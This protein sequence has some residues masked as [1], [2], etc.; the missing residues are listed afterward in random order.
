MASQ[1]FDD[2]D[3][4]DQR[5]KVLKAFLDPTQAEAMTYE[6]WGATKFVRGQSRFAGENDYN[7]AAEPSNTEWTFIMGNRDKSEEVF[8]DMLKPTFPKEL[9]IPNVRALLKRTTIILN[10]KNYIYVR[11]AGLETMVTRHHNIEHYIT[12]EAGTI[13]NNFIEDN[14]RRDE[15]E[16]N[17]MVTLES[18]HFAKL[19]QT[20]GMDNGNHVGMARDNVQ[21]SSS[22]STSLAAHR[23]ASSVHTGSLGSAPCTIES[24]DTQELAMIL[25]AMASRHNLSVVDLLTPPASPQVRRALKTEAFED[26]AEHLYK[27]AKEHHKAMIDL[28]SPSPS[29]RARQ[30]NLPQ[31]TIDEELSQLI[32]EGLMA[33]REFDMTE[34][35]VTL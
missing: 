35:D 20:K 29:K 10:T 2:G 25:G 21:P 32:K 3:L 33:E 19:L 11:M 5:P 8:L 28:C 30:S 17:K 31:A 15:A 14:A 26:A 1:V 16:Y 13:L 27:A 6:R 7:A 23:P 4:C 22:L 24:C 12:K 34:E 9:S 18:A